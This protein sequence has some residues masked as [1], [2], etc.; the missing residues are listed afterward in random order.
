MARLAASS[1][2]LTVG[3]SC[4]GAGWPGTG[5]WADLGPHCEACECGGGG[6]WT[7]RTVYSDIDSWARGASDGTQVTP[8]AKQ[9]QT[10]QNETTGWDLP[11]DNSNRRRNDRCQEMHAD[12]AV[13]ASTGRGD[14]AAG[15]KT[16]DARAAATAAFGRRAMADTGTEESRRRIDARR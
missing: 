6:S 16:D 7:R 13:P 1:W 2:P 5:F 3:R 15:C 4:R 14:E 8:E 9:S 10:E 11:G 12:T